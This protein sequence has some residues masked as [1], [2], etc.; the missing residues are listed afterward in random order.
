VFQWR[1]TVDPQAW[2]IQVGEVGLVYLTN[3]EPSVN[4]ELN[5]L[6]WDG[7]LGKDRQEAIK[8][9]IG[10]AFRVFEIERISASVV[11]TNAPL[12]NILNHK[13]GFVLEGVTRRGARSGEGKFVDL[14]RYGLLK[15][16][17]L[18]CQLITSLVPTT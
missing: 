5:V 18:P 6:F 2:F 11:H 3:V 10:T 15:E 1:L 14:I 17:L 9:V 13:L 7:K 8:A 4:A 16:E 12:R